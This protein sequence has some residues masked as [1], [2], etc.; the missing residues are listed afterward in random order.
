[1]L[2]SP[3]IPA[4]PTRPSLINSRSLWSGVV[5]V[6]IAASLTQTGL[7][8]PG[9]EVINWG[10]FGQLSQFFLA[11]FTPDL[12]PEFLRVMGRATLVTFAYAVCGTTL[13]VVFGFVGGVLASESWWRTVLPGSRLGPPIWLMIRGLLA[14]PRAIHELVWGLLFLNILGLDPLVA[15]VAI[16]VP[17]SAI[18]A[19]VFSEI[20]DETPQDPLKVLL[21]SGVA[22]ATAWLYGLL[23]QAF[24]NLLSYASYRFECALRSAAVLGVIGAGGLGYEI[25][26][27]LQSLRYSQL[28]TG[29]YTLIILNGAIDVWSAWIRRQMGFT[30]RLDLNAHKRSEH[31]ETSASA[32][33]APQFWGEMAQSPTSP[34]GPDVLA[35]T[36]SIQHSKSPR[37][38]DLGG[39]NSQQMGFTPRFD[40][41]SRKRSEY[42][43]TSALAP[44]APQSWGEMA[45]SPASP[46]GLDV[47]ASTEAIQHSTSPRMGD[48]GDV[49]DTFSPR[50]PLSWGLRCSW[51]VIALAIPL[52]FFGL[53]IGWHRLWSS[54]THQLSHEFFGAAALP[55]WPSLATL[56]TLLH[57]ASLTLAM[58]IL[59]TTLAGIGGILL[60][61]PAAQTFLTPESGSL[62]ARGVLF[63]SRLILL[64]SRAI[65]APIWALVF[66]FVLFPG[67]LPGAL[68]LAVHNFGILGRLMAEVNENLDD[69][70]MR[71]LQVLGA[72]PGQMI[73]YGILPQNLGRFLAYIFYR[74]EVCIRET[75]IVGLVGAGGLGRLMTEQLSSFDYSGLTLTLGCFIL[76]TFLV[77]LISQQMRAN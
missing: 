75:V 39:H 76:L 10:G 7:F 32:P 37:M 5:L 40:L 67:I 58:S 1:M 68:A 57:L 74:W 70:P 20:L 30:S 36:E 23:P 56:Q 12:S 72:S 59:A 8:Q 73:L 77:D 42:I 49:S 35:S 2:E 71:S 50:P 54:R 9:T 60:S 38:G 31:S 34:T 15:V 26:L 19:K 41:N 52:C 47:L 43:K 22:P 61:F 63:A 13:S 17:F 51:G 21:N 29:F 11:S 25:F 69:R 16:A 28:W 24:P 64:I 4:Q 3:P 46:T 6:A 18:V 27:S 48:L 33:P 53:G 44:P 14:F 62:R 66:L 45:Q 55:T 65:P